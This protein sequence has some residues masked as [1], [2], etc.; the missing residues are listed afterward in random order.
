ML[1][2]L[3]LM[4]CGKPIQPLGEKNTEKTQATTSMVMPLQYTG[5]AHE[6]G[7]AATVS[8][9]TDPQN[10]CTNPGTLVH[11]ETTEA[12]EASLAFALTGVPTSSNDPTVCQDGVPYCLLVEDG[13]VLHE[14]NFGATLSD[15]LAWNAIDDSEVTMT[16]PNPQPFEICQGIDVAVTT[17]FLWGSEVISAGVG[18]GEV[19]LAVL[20]G[21]CA[22]ECGTW[23]ENMGDP[24][25]V[26][27]NGDD[28]QCI[29]TCEVNEDCADH[30][31][32]A[33]PLCVQGNSVE[34]SFCY[35]SD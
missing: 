13:W 24:I 7:L 4:A 30:C 17:S 31:E 35:C 9:L 20:T 1:A 25:C 10:D 32:D 26:L 22:G 6:F 16:S 33:R 11:S 12:T 27:V 8:I 2:V 18:V 23:A 21:S 14:T 19:L 15:P 34:Q 5:V 3:A 28:A 29:P